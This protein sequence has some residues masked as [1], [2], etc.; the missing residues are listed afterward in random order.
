MVYFIEVKDGPI[1]I[2]YTSRSIGQRF[3][4]LQSGC[5]Y[6]LKVLAVIDEG[7]LL[8]ERRLHES[9]SLW[10]VPF[11][12][13]WYERDPLMRFV[14]SINKTARRIATGG[15]IQVEEIAD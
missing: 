10:R 3:K 4:E 14:E 15:L 11:T 6:P 13:E 2:G 1:K 9:Y 7:D 5:P 8:M 12:N